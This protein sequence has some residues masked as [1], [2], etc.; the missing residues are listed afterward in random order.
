MT[1]NI[2][3]V[4]F[5]LEIDYTLSRFSLLNSITFAGIKQ[6]ICWQKIEL[7]TVFAQIEDL[8]Y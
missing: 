5:W 6:M 8:I 2:I 1:Y 7:I 4:H 3:N